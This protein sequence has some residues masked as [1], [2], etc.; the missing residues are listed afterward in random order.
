MEKLA[1]QFPGKVGPEVRE[2]V[3]LA[4]APGRGKPVMAYA[5]KSRSANDYRKVIKW[6]LKKFK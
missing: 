5:P 3:V 2:R 6:M 1:E 4:E